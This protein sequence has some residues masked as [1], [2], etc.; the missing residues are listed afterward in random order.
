MGGSDSFPWPGS[1]RNSVRYMGAKRAIRKRVALS[2][3]V[4]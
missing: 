4:S 1:G 2:L 3:S